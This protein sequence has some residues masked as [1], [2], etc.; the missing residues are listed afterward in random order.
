MQSREQVNLNKLKLLELLAESTSN[1]I[2]LIIVFPI[3][4]SKYFSKKSKKKRKMPQ[5]IAK[6]IKR[7]FLLLEKV[8]LLMFTLYWLSDVLH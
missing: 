1:T 6:N 5:M 7:Q 3:T 2:S 8:P 4:F